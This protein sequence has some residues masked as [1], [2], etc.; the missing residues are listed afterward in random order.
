MILKSINDFR[1]KNKRNTNSTVRK[2]TN[3][4][5]MTVEEIMAEVD[6]Q[7]REDILETLSDHNIREQCIKSHSTVKKIKETKRF[8]SSIELEEQKREQI[9]QFILDKYLITGS[10]KGA[11]RGKKLEKIV[12]D[13]LHSIHFLKDTNRFRIII[14]EK[15]QI[16]DVHERPDWQIYDKKTGKRL[17]GYTQVDL[18]TGGAQSNRGMK[19]MEKQDYDNYK[20]LSVVAKK[21]SITG[22]R[23]T[24]VIE[25][26]SL[27]FR[28]DRLCYPS[29]IEKIAKKFFGVD[30]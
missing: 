8:L 22:D 14:Q 11:I 25:I 19:Y 13:Q 5:L 16:K 29:G 18:W 2:M 10:L 30:L 27:G 28:N 3:T 24:K 26:F 1:I 15:L 23:K 17:I 21:P 9:F 6:L 7:Y 4:E 20:F 12:E